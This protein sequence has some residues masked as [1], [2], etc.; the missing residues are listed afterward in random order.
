MLISMLLES[1]SEKH[2]YKV[3]AEHCYVKA[4]QLEIASA[5]SVLYELVSAL[6]C[7]A[8]SLFLRKKDKELV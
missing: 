4:E 3:L 5:D 6:F 2:D 1:A 8:K 7:W